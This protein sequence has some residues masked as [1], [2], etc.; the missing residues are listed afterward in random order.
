M[1]RPKGKENRMS[2]D[3]SRRQFVKSSA[4]A[5]A[6]AAATGT[7]ASY[8]ANSAHAEES[9]KGAGTSGSPAASASSDTSAPSKDGIEHK[10][11]VCRFCG[12]GCGILCGVKDGKLVS[13]IAD[14]ENG[15]NKGV[16][17]IKGYYLAKALYG[18]DRLTT[19]LIR[20]DPATKGTATGLE[21]ASWDEALDLIA[22][23]LKEAW[24]NDPT[25]IMFW[26]SGQQPI[27]EGYLTTKFWK[28]GLLSNNLE[29]NARLCM[30]SAV[31]AMM[32]IFQTDEPSGCY[33]DI[34]NADVLVTWGANMAEA[35]PIL[36]ARLVA[37]QNADPNVVHVDLGTLRT[38]TS[39]NATRTLLFRPGSDI[40]IANSI[41][42]YIVSNGLYNKEFVEQHCQFKMG[43]EDIGNAYE[44]GYD[45]SD[46]GQS[47]DKVW[48]VEF[49]E[50]AQRLSEYTFERA[51]EISGVAVEDL[52]Y[53]AKLYADP[54]KKVTSLWTMG[55]NEHNRG[56]W[57]NH[58]LFNLH[59]LT[60]KIG[61]PGNGPFS[62][63][64]Q[65]TACGTAREV[66]TFSHR[67]PA[68]LLVANEQHRRYTEAIWNL[69]EGY[70]DAIKK[71]GFH[72]VKM[73]REMSKGNMD[74]MW[75]AHN[76]WAQSMP[77]LTRFLGK[78]P[79]YPGIF[80]TFVVVDEVYPTISTTY[81]D[82]VLPVAFWV[83]REGQFGN[84]ERRTAIFEKCVDA[85]GEAKWDAWALMQ[86]AQRVLDGEKIGD[87]D[88]FDLLFGDVWDRTATDADGFTGAWRGDE[89]EVSRTVWE[90]YRTFSNPDLNERAKAIN[91]N[92]DGTFDGKLKME[93]KRLAP[94]DVILEKHGMTWP[95]QE[96]DGDW[97]ETKW[98]FANGDQ[99]AG[100][101][102]LNVEHYGAETKDANGI[103]FYKS[104]GGKPSVVFRPYE[105]PA[106][107]PD[108]DYP[109]FLCTGRL[110]EHWHTGSMTRR[111]PELAAALP[112]A[113][114]DMHPDD[115]AALGLAD[116]DRV[117]VTSR[118]GSFEITLS[119]AGRTQPQP[120]VVYAPFFAQESLVNAAVEDYYC[121][122]SKE[123]DYKKTCVRV[124]KV[125]AGA[126]TSAASSAGASAGGDG[127]VGGSTGSSGDAKTGEVPGMVYDV[128]KAPSA[129]SEAQVVGAPPV[130]PSNH[131]GYFESGGTELCVSCH[132]AAPDADGNPGESTGPAIP[133]N[134]YV[135]YET[136]T[137]ELEGRF[138]SCQT[139]HPVDVAAAQ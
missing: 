15:S 61:A 122:L 40:A 129:M 37:R 12:C 80:S 66:G 29:P 133:R 64:G 45:A 31:V 100:Y 76:N 89:R 139:C 33:E 82:V 128:T 41:A 67:L 54:T 90:E 97:Y 136:D 56:T 73:F 4:A 44:D 114:L 77:N 108:D 130:S 92:A 93:A 119:T 104:A 83:E 85:P 1:A 75:T 27:V 138:R 116:G 87:A 26:G 35:H 94:Y 96:V 5:M 18:G 109:F 24:K 99:K 13:T 42:N 59:L 74:F 110:L 11:A 113:T 121:P 3:V 112:E 88:A 30:A 14:P 58:C 16:C 43:T 2:M 50:Y 55:V 111:I 38:R 39:A 105:G 10:Q 98:R 132:G 106:E 71:P 62:L 123:P 28:A 115:A 107:E 21:P 124:E 23:K 51:S 36:Y 126:E 6:V 118:H 70:L 57:M 49:D 125:E 103:S 19:P 22:S 131:V 72:T 46:I 60:G 81:A 95:A 53:L 78:D 7:L 79:D 8:L 86:V 17:C 63:T 137:Q 48:N 117:R 134:H 25:R 32:N 34:D 52:E 68:D 20:R 91:D 9:A 84:G 135:V 127:T 102:Q 69:P 47:V 120:G 101:D 65:P